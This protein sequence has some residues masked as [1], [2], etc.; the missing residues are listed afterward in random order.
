MANGGGETEAQISHHSPLCPCISEGAQDR[1][2][3]TV[4]AGGKGS[5]GVGPGGVPAQLCPR[6]NEPAPVNLIKG[7]SPK[8]QL[9]QCQQQLFPRWLV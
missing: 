1:T 4:A 7:V 2:L 6:V 8:G 9:Q 3:G 5:E